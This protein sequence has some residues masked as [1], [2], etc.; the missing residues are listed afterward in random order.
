VA[1]L[2]LGSHS[3]SEYENALVTWVRPEAR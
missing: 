1:R 2:T 3:E